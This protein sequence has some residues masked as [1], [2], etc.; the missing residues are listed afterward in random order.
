MRLTLT[1]YLTLEGHSIAGLAKK[2]GRSR[3]TV[4]LWTKDKALTTVIDFD[5][6][7]G[8]VDTVEVGKMTTIKGVK[9]R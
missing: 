9:T 2:I 1:N 8:D 3:E 5:V 4:R 6:T 7:S